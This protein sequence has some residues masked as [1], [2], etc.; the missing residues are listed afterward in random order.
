MLRLF[1]LSVSLLLFGVMAVQ[2]P[3]AQ[4]SPSSVRKILTRTLP[5]C[6]PLARRMHLEG[7]VRMM[8]TVAADGRV[9]SVDVLGGHP[10][11]VQAAQ[12]AVSKWKW[13]PAEKESHELVEMKFQAQ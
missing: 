8:V 7:T 9:R 1:V 11:L 13:V 10:L 12:D 3:L 2:T 6:P 4:D 5:I